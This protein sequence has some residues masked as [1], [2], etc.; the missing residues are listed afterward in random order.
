MEENE[1]IEQNIPT[2]NTQS[3]C[4]QRVLQ[5]D[6]NPPDKGTQT[7]PLRLDMPSRSV[8]IAHAE[9]VHK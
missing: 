6:T 5:F 7:S 1:E 3:R 4:L 2:S 8:R 9:M